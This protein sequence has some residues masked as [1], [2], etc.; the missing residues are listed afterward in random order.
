MNL[1]YSWKFSTGEKFPEKLPDIQK[2]A[3]KK[4]DKK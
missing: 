4:M 1:R 2:T 3:R